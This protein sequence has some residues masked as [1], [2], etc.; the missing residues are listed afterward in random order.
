M[1]PLKRV[2]ANVY[3]RD[4]ATYYGKFKVGGQWTKRRL[5]SIQIRAAVA[6]VRSKQADHDRS[7]FGHAE[8]P[9]APP[10]EDTTIAALAEKWRNADCPNPHK[11]QRT[12]E[13]L[14]ACKR[15]LKNLETFFGK[16]RAQ[17]ITAADCHAYHGHRTAGPHKVTKGTGNRTVDVE[18]TTLSNLLSWATV[19]GSK[20]GGI[21]FNPIREGRLKFQRERDT[22]HCTETMPETGSELHAIARH[23]MS[24]PGSAVLAWQLL[25][26]ALTG[27]RTSEIL[28]L[29]WDATRTGN[30][31]QPGHQ[32]DRY[33]WIQ[34]S[35]SGIEPAVPKIDP[36]LVAHKCTSTHALTDCLIA[37]EKW[38]NATHP[39]TPWY[40]PSRNNPQKP[41]E[42]T[43]LAKALNR[44]TETLGLPHRTSHGL[45][46]YYVNV[47]RR[48]RV[49]DTRIA[50]R[51]G[52][53]SGV[54]LIEKTYG[55]PVKSYQ[56]ELDF[57][58]SDPDDTSPPAWQTWLE[59]D[60]PARN[61]IQIADL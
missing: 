58:P 40:F 41:V 12:G 42:R 16:I 34:R 19:I 9:F 15:D 7:K 46:A 2:A 54:A 22:R 45:R 44:A 36:E 1:T 24:E 56:N 29:R 33:L 57:L 17:D 50:E 51:L 32:D 55:K 26:E 59:H 60:Q 25:L 37:L 4:G 31:S 13:A 48:W 49:A 23:I 3:T 10:P 52:H 14:V 21:D 43:A 5:A 35:K 61:I 18:L 39:D 53:R 20:Y 11:E 8:D 27:C 30:T 38:R 6:E 47:L 28:R